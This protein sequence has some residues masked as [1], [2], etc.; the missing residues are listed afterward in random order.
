MKHPPPFLL[1]LLRGAIGKKLVVKHYRDGKVIMT[2]FPGMSGIVP[3]ESQKWRRRLFK[4]AVTYARKVFQSPT[5]REE[6]RKRLRRPKRLF[7]ALMKE[8]F[9]LRKEKEDYRQRRINKWQK[10]WQLNKSFVPLPVFVSSWFNPSAPSSAL[11]VLCSE[12]NLYDLAL[13]FRGTGEAVDNDV[14]RSE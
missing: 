4:K 12:K 7:Q 2:R 1:R 5:L 10:T 14:Y 9:R 8:W 13:P 11:L 6:K 3:S